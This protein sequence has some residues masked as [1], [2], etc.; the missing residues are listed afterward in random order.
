MLKKLT[1]GFVFVFIM[2]LAAFSVQ[3]QDAITAGEPVTGELT[4]DTFA[5]EYTYEGTAD[6]VVVITLAPVDVLGDLNNPAI[7]VNDPD[8]N[9]LLRYDGYGKST[10]VV[11]LP[12]DGTYTIVATRTDDK[13]GTS[14]GEY[15]LTVVQPQELAAGDSVD[16]K[17]A[18]DETQYYVYR[19]DADFVLSYAREGEYAPEFTVNT[20]DT[21]ITVGSLD[22]VA[23]VGGKL[24]T[25]GAVG[26]I[27]GGN[28]YVIKVG[29]ALFDFYFDA[30]D[31][32]YT[33]QI[34]EAGK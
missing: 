18:S 2:S 12:A 17:V 10:V 3:A 8:G 14:V 15:T 29:Q 20:I 19:G 13:A 27:P 34:S 33:L 1:L 24:A 5:V 7:I 4:E 28:V 31:A 9:E 23:T 32:T 22:T 11:Q 21:E 16:E 6:E 30:V 26:I 25:Q